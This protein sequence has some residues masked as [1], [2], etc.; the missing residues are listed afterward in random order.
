MLPSP[1]KERS[2]DLMKPFIWGLAAIFIMVVLSVIAR[3]IILELTN[4]IPAEVVWLTMAGVV[5]LGM[6]IVNTGKGPRMI[7]FLLSPNTLAWIAGAGI[8][9]AGFCLVH[10]ADGQTYAN[11]AAPFDITLPVNW[12]VMEQ[13]DK[14]QVTFLNLD[15]A[16]KESALIWIKWGISDEDFR[17]YSS[18]AMIKAEL[19]EHPKM[20]SLVISGDRIPVHE[21]ILQATKSMR[22]GKVFLRKNSHNIEITYAASE[23]LWPTVHPLF[24]KT[25][26]SLQIKQ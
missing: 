18:P 17:N 1:V 13:K 12:M 8:C 2:L 25:L 3:P 5:S 23:G 16:K 14:P 10:A 11:P 24:E 6:W 15:K 7:Q 26:K 19:G 22:A 4:A 20:L 9:S 21:G